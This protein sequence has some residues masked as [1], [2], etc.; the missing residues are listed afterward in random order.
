MQTSD[1]IVFCR[2]T[3][4]PL[5]ILLDAAVGC[6]ASSK[7]DDDPD[8]RSSLMTSV[9]KVPPTLRVSDR[10]AEGV[11]TCLEQLL[12]KCTLTSVDQVS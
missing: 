11:L 12:S 1:Y 2:Y 7:D 10:V 5:L 3:L 9:P 8:G 4:F 6:R